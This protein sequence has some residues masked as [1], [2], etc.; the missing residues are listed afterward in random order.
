MPWLHHPS[1]ERVREGLIGKLKQNIHVFG[2]SKPMVFLCGGHQSQR[3]KDL[4]VYLRNRTDTLVFFAEDVWGTVSKQRGSDALAMEKGLADLA[5]IVIIIVES[6]GTLAELGAFSLHE[7]L[8]K[9]LLPVMDKEHENNESFIN[10]GPLETVKTCSLFTPAIHTDFDVI[11][12]A[13]G[14]IESR[15]SRIPRSHRSK[16]LDSA[17]IKMSRKHLLIFLV[18]LVSLIFPVTL[19]H[20]KYYV[21]KVFGSSQKLPIDEL[22]ELAIAMRLLRRVEREPSGSQAEFLAPVDT[23]RLIQ[24]ADLHFESTRARIAS[25][26]LGIPSAREAIEAAVADAAN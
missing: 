4:A 17:S 1:Y 23:L 21:T 10:T 2:R 14:E 25:S 11:L 7:D 15:L 8:Q 12:Q 13:S 18:H 6:A 24:T 19:L 20:L 5:D 26:L 3:R 16:K 22:I 9:K